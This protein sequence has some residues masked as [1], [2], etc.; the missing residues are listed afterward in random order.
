MP[1]G[2]GHL[3]RHVMPSLATRIPML[4]VAGERDIA[5][6]DAVQAVRPLVERGRLNKIELYPS[7]LHGYKLLRLEPKVTSTLF[8][9]LDTTLKTAPSP[10]SP[11]T[12]SSPSPSP[13]SRP[14]ATPGPAMPS[15]TSPRPKPRRPR[16]RRQAQGRRRPEARG[17]PSQARTVVTRSSAVAVPYT[18]METRRQGRRPQ[19]SWIPPFPPR[20]A[21]Y[22]AYERRVTN[23]RDESMVLGRETQVA[24]AEVRSWWPGGDRWRRGRGF[25]ISGERPIIRL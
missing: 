21:A 15:R 20:I 17:R 4:L 25:A 16:T 6:K 8:Q 2:S 7:P 10:G 1:E 24:P 12:T 14:S 5:S 23:V 11:S 3:L 19:E 18:R 13:R 22:N 9:F